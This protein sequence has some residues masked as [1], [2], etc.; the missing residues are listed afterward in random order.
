MVDYFDEPEESAAAID[1]TGWLHTGDVGTLDKAGY[2]R[3]VDRT[4][5]LFIVGGFNAYP[6]EIEAMMLEHP[7]LVQVA[8]VGIADAILGEVGCAFVVCR[9]GAHLT[10]SELT[11]WCRNRMAN[12]KVPRRIELVHELPINAAGKVLKYVLRERASAHSS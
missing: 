4:K 2:L 1:A 3:I 9:D 5:D 12:Y 6:A 8:V 7:A 11:S 10:L